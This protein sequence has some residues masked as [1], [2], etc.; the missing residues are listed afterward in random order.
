MFTEGERPSRYALTL[1]VEGSGDYAMFGNP[2]DRYSMFEDRPCWEGTERSDQP[3]FDG[4][5]D[6]DEVSNPEQDRSGSLFDRDE[7][8]HETNAVHLPDRNTNWDDFDGLIDA[9]NS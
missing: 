8:H 3:V 5:D 7:P 2:D 6:D 9:A 1:R 4:P